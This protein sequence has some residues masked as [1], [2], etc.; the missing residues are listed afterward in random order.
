MTK[1]RLLILLLTFAFLGVFGTATIYYAQGYRLNNESLTLSQK[2][3][4]VANSEPNGAEVI[5][6]G[7]LKTATNNT[8]ALD[9]GNHDII[10]QKE[11]F[12]PWSK[13]IV[14]AEEEVTQINAFLLPVAPSLSALTLSGA[15]N[16]IINTEMTKIAFAVF[17][18]TLPAQAGASPSATPIPNSNGK[19]KSGLWIFEMNNLPLGFNREPRQ[20][21]SGDL[22]GASWEFSPDNTQILLTTK[23]GSFLVDTAKLNTSSDLVNIASSLPTIRKEWQK[24]KDRKL[25]S[26]L[27]SFPEK[28]DTAMRKFAK[29]INLSPDANKILYTASVSGTLDNGLVVPLPGASTQV[30]SRQLEEGNKYVYDTKE[31]KNFVVG[32]KEDIIYWLPNSLNLLNP[33]TNGVSVLDYDGTNKKVVFTGNYQFPHAY[34]SSS[35]GRA[36]ILTSFGSAT[37]PLNLYWLSLK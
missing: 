1:V 28:L 21:T 36:I 4:L 37:S 29:D 14:I 34:P 32:T 22:G 7:E 8:I 9:P 5:V 3:L 33:Q 10:I 24:D 35:T 31:D 2:G 6:D 26:Q 11:G 17:P 13:K 15:S 18:E 20:I 23:T 16:P 25:E 12:I 19:D 27:T 30:E